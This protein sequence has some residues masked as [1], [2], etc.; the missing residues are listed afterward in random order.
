M[1]TECQVTPHVRGLLKSDIQPGERVLRWFDPSPSLAPFVQRIWSAQWR[2]PDGE[3]RLQPILPHPS[4][5]LVLGRCTAEVIGVITRATI[6]RLEGVDSAFGAKL[7]P[8]A[9]RA[10]GV[11][12]PSMLRDGSVPVSDLLGGH[13]RSPG[14]NPEDVARDIE[15][16][17]LARAPRHDS[18]SSRAQDIA[19]LA[20]NN[21]EIVSV[22]QLATMLKLSVRSVQ[23]VCRRSLGVSPKWLIRCFRLQDAL[24]RIEL[25]P[26]ASLAGL[27]QDLGY[28]DQAHFTRDFKRV[29]GVSPGRY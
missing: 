11:E 15:T 10:F 14:N 3:H 1:V 17:L 13:L 5:N 26:E 12:T 23:D 19:H 2:I 16:Y 9:L 22:Q 20:E 4:A 29:T 28:F 7:Q 25:D 6:R 21:R 24:A 27:A 8:G 18:V